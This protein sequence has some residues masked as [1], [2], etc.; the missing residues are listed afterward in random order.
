MGTFRSAIRRYRMWTR[1]VRRTVIP[2][3]S[4]KRTARSTSAAI[5]RSPRPLVSSVGT[6]RRTAAGSKPGPWSVIS[7]VNSDVRGVNVMHMAMQLCGVGEPWMMALLSASPRAT[8]KSSSDSPTNPASVATCRSRAR[9]VA[10]FI[11]SAVNSNRSLTSFTKDTGSR[12]TAIAAA[13]FAD[14]QLYTTKAHL[15]QPVWHE[16]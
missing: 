12:R 16:F 1:V 4:R 10:A 2:E 13:R 5:M 15:R 11:G 9:A 7:T 6:G 14:G 3:P 8:S